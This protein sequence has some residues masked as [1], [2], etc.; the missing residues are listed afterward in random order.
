MAKRS[1]D[2]HFN[3][4]L[5]H[6]ILTLILVAVAVAFF[7]YHSPKIRLDASSESLVLE[8]DDA[9]Q[10]YRSIRARYGSD[11]FLVVT[12]SP[13]T[14]L[15]EDSALENLRML[16][17]DLAAISRVD[18]VISLLD[19]PLVQSPP[20]SL[21]EIE[22]GVPTLLS[23]QTDRELA[24]KEILNSPVYHNLIISPDGRTTAIQVNFRKDETWHRLLESRNRLLEQRLTS[25]LTND[26]A[27]RLK[28]LSR[29]FENHSA[30]LQAQQAKDIAQVREILSRHRESATLFLGGVPMIAADSISFIRQDM[31]AFGAAVLGFIFAILWTVF[32]KPRWIVLP[33]LACGFTGVIMIGILGLVGWPI[34]VVSSNFLALLL[35]ITLSL[36]VHL[37]VRYRELQSTAPN[38]PKAELVRQTVASKAAP[39]FYTVVTTIVAFGSLVFSGIRTVMDFGMMMSIGVL[40]AFVVVFALIPA[41]LMLMPATGVANR[42]SWTDEITGYVASLIKRRRIIIPALFLCLGVLSFKG[43]SLLSVENR[44]LD[45]FRPSTEIYQGMELIDNELGGT[46]PLDVVI[47]MPVIADDPLLDDWVDP[48]AE[49]FG[50][51]TVEK[52]FASTSYWFNANRLGDVYRIHDYLDGLSETGKVL[53]IASA[54]RLLKTIDPQIDRENFELSVLY[55]SMPEEFKDLLFKPYMS[56]DGNQIRFAIRVFE[57]DPTLQRAALM[58]EIRQ[59]LSTEFKLAPEQVNL[60]GMLVLYNNMLQ[61]LFRSQILTLG[62][63]FLAIMIMF[64]IVFRDLKLASVAII[65]NIFAAGLVLGIMGWLRIPLDLMT[66]TIAAISIGIAVDDTIHYVHRFRDEFVKDG[67]YWASVR[68]S[69]ASIGRAMY[70]TTITITLGFSILALSN[71][72]PTVYFGLL[73]GFAMLAALVADLA[74]LPLLLVWTRPLKTPNRS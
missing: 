71:F 47:D 65:P 22:K 41:A 19:V 36:C 62:A 69:H 18:S 5:S 59:H 28:L 46:T 44:F 4:V 60:T 15:F 3:F 56:E 35:I 67:D 32:R 40:V 10:F 42:N 70:Y 45:Y 8:T 66:I 2:R 52:G 73:T 50:M 54:M 1:A 12:F 34:T 58:D 37:I 17:D 39:C 51:E 38:T 26:E 68:R 11:D 74:L 16:R 31:L 9:L 29:Q 63:V 64:A 30:S 33:M 27:R 43:V 72:V 24:R 6:P 14:D 20:I 23:P 61:S 13:S 57:S 55:K 21:S 49:A 25:G 48:L 53:S 7:G